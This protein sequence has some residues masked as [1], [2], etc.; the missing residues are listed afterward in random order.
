VLLAALPLLLG[1]LLAVRPLLAQ[2]GAAAPALT[3]TA[4]TAVA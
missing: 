3:V 2:D 4:A 1:G